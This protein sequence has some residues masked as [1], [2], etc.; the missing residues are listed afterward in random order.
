M[1]DIPKWRGYF[2]SLSINHEADA[3]L[4]DEPVTVPVREQDCVTEVE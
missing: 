1:I 3:F 4:R 2:A